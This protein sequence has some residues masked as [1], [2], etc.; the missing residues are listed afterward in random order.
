MGQEEK[1]VGVTSFCPNPDV[2]RIR[3][4]GGTKTPNIKKIVEL[5]PDLIIANIEENPKNRIEELMKLVS[6]YLTYPRKLADN[7]TLIS[8]L[9]TL[10]D[11]ELSEK[12]S[13]LL[14]KS[15]LL[16]QPYGVP[17]NLRTFC[18][19]WADP[20][21]S[22]NHDTYINS[23][24]EYFG[25][26]NSTSNYRQRYPEIDLLS[27]PTIDLV[28]LPSEPFKFTQ[29]Q[30]K[31]LRSFPNLSDSIY[32]Y[33]DGRYLSWYGT[34]AITAIEKLDVQLRECI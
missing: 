2:S 25:L 21:M 15:K 6:V 4:V 8:N 5:A 23:V 3:S 29:K 13:D 19:I 7:Y 34:L 12:R 20:Y 30:E 31:H 27:L 32:I 18:P 24:L 1:I 16:L 11:L 10:L 17:F 26:V 22:I 28:L 33:V 14:D 9:I